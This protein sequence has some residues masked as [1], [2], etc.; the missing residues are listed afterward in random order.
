MLKCFKY[1]YIF[2]IIYIYNNNC[3]IQI[4]PDSSDCL[5]DPHI[6][7][8]VITNM[9]NFFVKCFGIDPNA[10]PNYY[11]EDEEEEQVGLVSEIQENNEISLTDYLNSIFIQ[12]A[13]SSR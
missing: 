8:H 4:Y 7:Q 12:E 9:E 2:Y 11:V 3:Y 1:F 13:L 6:R 10:E 5:E